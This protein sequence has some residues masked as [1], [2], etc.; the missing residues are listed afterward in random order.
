MALSN[1]F[2]RKD[3]C[4]HCADP[5]C[6][7]ACPAMR[8]VQY[9]NGIVD[10]QQENCI[11]CELCASGCPYNIPSS[12]RPPRRFTSAHYVRRVAGLGT[13][14]HQGLVPRDV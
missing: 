1:G 2:M 9:T 3:Q 11:G 4:M 6:L 7:R 14:L 10:F 8:I 5:G 13:S 12:T